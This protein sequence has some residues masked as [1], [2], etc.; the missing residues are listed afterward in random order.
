MGGTKS[1]RFA[2]F[3]TINKLFISNIFAE[4]Y[5]SNRNI[6]IKKT[7]IHDSKGFANFQ[8]PLH[9]HIDPVDPA[10]D[11][12]LH[13][14]QCSGP[15]GGNHRTWRKPTQVAYE[16][17]TQIRHRS[18]PRH[19]LQYHLTLTW[20]RCTIPTARPF[21]HS[22]TFISLHLK[23]C[24]EQLPQQVSPFLWA[25]VTSTKWMSCLLTSTLS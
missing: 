22:F 2:Y 20:T 6:F 24:N 16:L 18:S 9:K 21:I 4:L 14:E 5:N 25:P 11:T 13:R 17:H 3:S 15:V 10:Q 19:V 23:D 8:A 12:R 1:K 7:D